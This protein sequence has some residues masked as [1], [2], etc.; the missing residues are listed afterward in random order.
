VCTGSRQHPCALAT[1]SGAAAGILGRRDGQITRDECLAQVRII[2]AEADLPVSGDLE[3]GF[4]DTPEAVAEI[5]DG[6]AVL[7]FNRPRHRNAFTVQVLAAATA[8]V[9]LR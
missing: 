3:K 1:S 8:P 4:G 6:V 9:P 2:V 5:D 7:T